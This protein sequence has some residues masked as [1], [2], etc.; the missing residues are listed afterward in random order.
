VDHSQFQG[1]RPQPTGNINNPLETVEVIQ[2]IEVPEANVNN[3]SREGLIK[4]V[5]KRLKSEGP[6]NVIESLEIQESIRNSVGPKV[7]PMFTCFQKRLY[8]TEIYTETPVI[9]HD[10]T[11]F[12]AL[13]TKYWARLGWLGKWRNRLLLRHL[14]AVE[15]IWVCPRMGLELTFKGLCRPR[16]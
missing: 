1:L 9:Y 2:P 3:Q 6:A 5:L 4:R 12:T 15:P 7:I 13:R 16:S 10:K 14:D 11:T 8:H